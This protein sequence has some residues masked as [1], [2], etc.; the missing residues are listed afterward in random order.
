[1]AF[2]VTKAE[3]SEQEITD[4]VKARVSPQKCLRGGVQFVDSIPKSA[5]G[6]IL[7]RELRKLIQK[8]TELKS[9]LQMLPYGFKVIYLVTSFLCLVF[10][11]QV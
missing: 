4:Y 2:I 9:K 5:S 11:K 8:S 1:M 10:F 3:I 7:R 6:K